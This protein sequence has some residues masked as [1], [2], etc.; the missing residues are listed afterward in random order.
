MEDIVFIKKTTS[1]KQ[2]NEL[3][4]EGWKLVS[5]VAKADNVVYILGANSDLAFKLK[6][7]TYDSNDL[8]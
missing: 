4:S 6:L 5:V 2:A 7:V 1:T 8:I 3:L